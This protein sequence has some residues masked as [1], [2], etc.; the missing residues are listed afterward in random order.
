ME[1]ITVLLIH[2][3]PQKINLK[4]EN[5]NVITAFDEI[6]A[7]E[8]LRTYL[9]DII[10]INADFLIDD[11]F[12]L[13]HY[14]QKTHKTPVIVLGDKKFDEQ[15]FLHGA[16]DY[17]AYPISIRE[18]SSRIRA[19]VR[20]YIKQT[21]P[22]IKIDDKLIF[23]INTGEVVVSGQK[24]RLR[25]IE[26]RLLRHLVENAGWTIPSDVLLSKVWG[27][28]YRDNLNYLHLYINYLRRD[29][30]DDPRD[31]RYILTV[32]GIGYRFIKKPEKIL[33]EEMC[34]SCVS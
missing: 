9:P 30:N 11:D 12:K 29:I 1:N 31:P 27:E 32:R 23:N 14:V 2:K 18:L 24:K 28:E 21:T 17:M 16:D 3:N 22:I 6:S 7:I 33:N 20:R 34:G 5:F 25:P 8:K 13:L 10:L 26:Y 15:A 19:I 4:Y